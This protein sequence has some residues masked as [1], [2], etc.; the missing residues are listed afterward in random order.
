VTTGAIWRYINNHLLTKYL[1]TSSFVSS[2]EHSG[3]SGSK[4]DVV[5]YYGSGTVAQ[6]DRRTDRRTTGLRQ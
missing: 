1:L 4:Y 6:T 5:M 2:A 3:V